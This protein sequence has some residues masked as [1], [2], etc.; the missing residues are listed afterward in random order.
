VFLFALGFFL[1]ETPVH[2]DISAGFRVVNILNLAI[3]SIWVLL[4]FFMPARIKDK[5]FG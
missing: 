4:A 1:W 5:L 2:Y 3:A